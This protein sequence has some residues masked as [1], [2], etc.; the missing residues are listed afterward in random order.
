MLAPALKDI[1]LQTSSSQHQPE[2][3]AAPHAWSPSK[4]AT[5]RRAHTINGNPGK[6]QPEPAP[7]D[8]ATLKAN[9]ATHPAEDT[10]V[11]WD[12]WKSMF[13]LARQANIFDL[14]ASIADVAKNPLTRLTESSLGLDVR[15]IDMISTTVFLASLGNRPIFTAAILG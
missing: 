2:M 6:S 15:V 13:E 4:K 12:K 9:Q 10:T 3:N 5:N 11:L 8:L 1:T 7:Q 14:P